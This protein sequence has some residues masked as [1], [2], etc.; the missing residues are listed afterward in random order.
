MACGVFRSYACPDHFLKIDDVPLG[1]LDVGL[2][3]EQGDGDEDVSITALGA[4]SMREDLIN[5]IVRL[6]RAKL[7]F[8]TA[9]GA[10]AEHVP[11]TVKPLL[12]KARNE[13]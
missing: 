12:L 6:D 4:C 11:V 9:G 13:I 7:Q 1:E 10:E 2:F 8:G 5:Q 3:A